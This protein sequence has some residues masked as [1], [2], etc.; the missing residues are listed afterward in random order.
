MHP[1]FIK[2]MDLQT[3]PLTTLAVI[4][5]SIARDIDDGE[6]D[7]RPLL[8]MIMKVFTTRWS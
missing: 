6:E 7:K 8:E 5:M 1:A 2:Q 4:A 3:M